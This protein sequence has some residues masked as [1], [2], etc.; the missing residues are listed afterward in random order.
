MIA[1]SRHFLLWL[2]VEQRHAPRRSSWQ[3]KPQPRTVFPM[4][5]QV[6]A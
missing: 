1:L 3:A 5:G 2:V 6:E 4:F